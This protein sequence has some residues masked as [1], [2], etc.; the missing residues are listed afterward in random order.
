M[1]ERP[2]IT[3]REVRGRAIGQSFERGEDYL[4][5]GYVENLVLRGQV[6]TAEVVGSQYEPYLVEVHF[7]GNTIAKAICTC[8]YDRGGDCKHI[9]AVLLA[10]IRDRESLAERPLLATLLA[11]L[12]AEHLRAM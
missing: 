3:E 7:S 11:D 12:D 10:Y 9:V 8:P 1:E 4:E 6:L 5:G 2:L